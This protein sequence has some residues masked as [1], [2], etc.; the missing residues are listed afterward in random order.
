LFQYWRTTALKF[1]LHQ[2]KEAYAKA[3]QPKPL[4]VFH[5]GAECPVIRAIRADVEK[6]YCVMEA[7]LYG[8]G[9]ESSSE[10]VTIIDTHPDG[11]LVVIKYASERS[12]LEEADLRG[13]PANAWPYLLSD[14]D[15][16]QVKRLKLHCASKM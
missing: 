10:I 5:V 8:P 13:T 4:C 9:V 16:Y 15:I 1:L 3:L 7:M 6:V 12:I 2:C 11:F 14:T